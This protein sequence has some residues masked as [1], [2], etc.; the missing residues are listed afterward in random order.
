MKPT[1][2]TDRATVYQSTWLELAATLPTHMEGASLAIVDGPYGLSKADW[3]TFKSWD[4]FVEWY[5]PELQELSRV[6]AESANVYL[7]GTDTSASALRPLM[8]EL[9]WKRR[10]RVIWDKGIGFMAGK[11]DTAAMTNHYDLTEVCDH[12]QRNAWDLSGGAGATIAAA[13]NGDERNRASA[14]LASERERAGM[15]RR[16]LAAHFPSKTGRLTGCVSNWEGGQNFPTW[17][18]WFKCAAAMEETT[19]TTDRPYLVLPEVW[20][21]GGGLRASYDHLRAPFN[22]PQGVGNVWRAPTVAGAERLDHPCQKP[23]A[24]YDRLIRSSSRVGDVVL[25]PYGGTLRA[26]VACQRLP[27]SE[28]RRAIV[29]EPHGPYI[30]AVRPSLEWVPGGSGDQPSLFG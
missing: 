19:P 22:H 25:E 13:A 24:F 3:D 30:E 27:P 28:A 17:G 12:Y 10:T 9:G 1:I 11:I 8:A 7:W 14:F 21:K 5:R 26:A 29:C 16:D 18:V 15:T 2:K 4:H 6:L 20:E 23:L